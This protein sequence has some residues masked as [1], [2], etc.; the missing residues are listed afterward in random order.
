MLDQLQ[1]IKDSVDAL[2]DKCEVIETQLVA[3]Q[4]TS[5]QVGLSWEGI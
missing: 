2:Q 3:A 1:N 4:N 5:S